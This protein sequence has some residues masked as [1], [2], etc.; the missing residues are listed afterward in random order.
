MLDAD[1]AAVLRDQFIAVLGHDLRNPL[2]AI[3]A[4]TT[5][6]KATPLNDRAKMIVGQMEASGHRMERLIADVLDFARG[7][8]GGGVPVALQAEALVHDVIE[9]VVDELRAAWPDR[10][11]VS[12][13]QIARPVSCDP[14][15]VAQLLSNLVSNAL[16]HGAPDGEVH[17]QA[18]C[19]GDVFEISVTNT[20]DPIPAHALP[21][22]FKPFTRPRN[23]QPQA[24]LGLGLY[25][26][27]Q[28]ARGHAG[29]LDAESS[30]E[31]TRFRFVMPVRE[32]AEQR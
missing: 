27:S 25:I 19:D 1:E 31:R 18:R 29:S 13:I 30:T 6:L 17:V 7:R 28:I 3:Q 15:R 22:L 20:G 32:A 2:A 4:G 21:Q 12:D 9:Q 24:G 26:A 14:D 8:L 10:I 5:L 11:I 23:D 16:T